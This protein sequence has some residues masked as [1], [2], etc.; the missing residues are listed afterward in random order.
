[1]LQLMVPDQLVGGL[2]GCMHLSS[3]K[4]A[5]AAHGAGSHCAC[6]PGVQEPGQAL[7]HLHM[8][9]CPVFRQHISEWAFAWTSK[10]S[11]SF[12]VTA[13]SE[14]RKLP[15][16]RP[17]RTPRRVCWHRS[18]PHSPAALH[19]LAIGS[20]TPRTNSI[21]LQFQGCR[22][23]W[24]HCW[25][26]ECSVVALCREVPCLGGD[27]AAQQRHQCVLAQCAATQGLGGDA[28][29]GIQI[30][31]VAGTHLHKHPRRSGTLPRGIL[32]RR[33]HAS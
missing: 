30:T 11:L 15:W 8:E 16:G 10:K 5:L 31:P 32:A 3:P 24:E 25:C 29:D 2:Q 6:G 23:S 26:S 9:G 21:A 17:H 4:G 19:N 18:V 14:A 28:F 12:L 13:E 7:Q 27:G 33:I 1:M 22:W 20:T